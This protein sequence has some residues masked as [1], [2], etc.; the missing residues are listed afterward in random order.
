MNGGWRGMGKGV[1]KQIHGWATREP[2]WIV[3]PDLP[4]GASGMKRLVR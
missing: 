1:A 4:G 2:G 3:K